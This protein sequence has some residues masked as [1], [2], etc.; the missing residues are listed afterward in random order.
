M[1]LSY[2]SDI[3]AMSMFNSRIG[4]KNENIRNITN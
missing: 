1:T 4:M 3:I 2:E